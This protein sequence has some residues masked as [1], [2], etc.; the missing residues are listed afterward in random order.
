MTS[1]G[2]KSGN[3][4]RLVETLAITERHPPAPCVSPWLS[5]TCTRAMVRSRCTNAMFTVGSLRINREQPTYEAIPSSF[6]GK[7]AGGVQT[8]SRSF[9]RL[10]LSLRFRYFHRRSLTLNA[11]RRLLMTFLPPSFDKA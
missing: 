4:C 7:P 10:R 5:A 8:G 9:I 2:V 6:H 11:S 1:V 3:R